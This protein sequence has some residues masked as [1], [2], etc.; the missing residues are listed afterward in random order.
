LRRKAK[1][2]SEAEHLVKATQDLN[3]RQQLLVAHAL[4]HPD[5]R[6]TIDTYRRE[7][8]VVYA[9]GR[10]DLLGLVERRC[11]DQKRIGRKFYFTPRPSLAIELK[12]KNQAR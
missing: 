1:E 5:A 12:G 9:T 3:Q 6:Y 7:Y 10:S 2:V 11:L 4:R 8:G